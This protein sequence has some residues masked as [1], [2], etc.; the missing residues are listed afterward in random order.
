MLRAIALSLALLTTSAALAQQVP[1]GWRVVKDSRA[2]CQMAVP[3][4]WAIEPSMARAPEGRA[5]VVVHGLRPGQSWQQAIATAKMVMKPV[6][7]LEDGQTRV[8]FVYVPG[9]GR[10]GDPSISWYVA[11]PG[12]VTICTVEIEFRGSEV[13]PIARAVVATLGSAR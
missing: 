10:P 13:E 7:I 2:T 5:H 4:T 11:V 1:E 3:P 9:T 12:R 6:K 8:W